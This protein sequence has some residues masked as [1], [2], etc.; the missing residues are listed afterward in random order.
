M[1]QIAYWI[2]SASPSRIPEEHQVGYNEDWVPVP[3]AEDRD[4]EEARRVRQRSHSA[5]TTQEKE[6][7]LEKRERDIAEREA[8]CEELSKLWNECKKA[9]RL[10]EHSLTKEMLR[11]RSAAK[12]RK[13]GVMMLNN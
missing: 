3:T 12:N 8:L 13:K 10:R 5:T 6:R 11:S 9:N 1:E 4:R 2:L 7:E